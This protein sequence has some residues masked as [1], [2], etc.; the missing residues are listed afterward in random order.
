[1]Q[2]TIFIIYNQNVN[3]IISSTRSTSQIFCKTA[4][5]IKK[6]PLDW[7]VDLKTPKLSTSWH[8]SYFVWTLNQVPEH[9][10]ESRIITENDKT[11]LTRKA[12]YINLPTTTANFKMTSNTTSWRP[13]SGSWTSHYQIS[14]ARTTLRK[15]RSCFQVDS[16]ATCKQKKMSLIPHTFNW[17]DLIGYKS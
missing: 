1:M 8:F 7:W 12:K 11:H 2:F 6:V 14:R 3:F 10:K 15:F 17:W 13:W 5:Q 4:Y 16:M 9:L